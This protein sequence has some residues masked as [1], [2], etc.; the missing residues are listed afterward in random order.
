MNIIIE[1]QSDVPLE[2]VVDGEVRHT[3]PAGASVRQSGNLE[4]T[5]QDEKAE[6]TKEESDES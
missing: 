3:I 6:E 1:N 5:L 2:I 4:I